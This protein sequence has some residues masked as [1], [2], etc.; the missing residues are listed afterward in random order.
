MRVP[1]VA[2]LAGSGRIVTGV[3][4]GIAN[5]WTGRVAT[6]GPIFCGLRGRS[7]R[8]RIGSVSA[9]LL[10][11]CHAGEQKI[12]SSWLFRGS[13][14][15]IVGSGF[16]RADFGAHLDTEKWREKKIVNG[17]HVPVMPKS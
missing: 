5:G 12:R 7:A 16:R 15:S 14:S 17:S 3:G 6:L 13:G 2:R 8:R 11:H 10:G 4:E 9:A 1:L